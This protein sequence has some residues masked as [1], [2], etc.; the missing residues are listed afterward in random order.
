M[1]NSGSASQPISAS[2][3]NRLHSVSTTI[4]LQSPRLSQGHRLLSYQRGFV[5]TG[6]SPDTPLHDAMQSPGYYVTNRVVTNY[7]CLLT[8]L[9]EELSA[10]LVPSIFQLS[11]WFWIGFN[12]TVLILNHDELLFPTTCMQCL[13]IYF[14]HSYYVLVVVIFCHWGLSIFIRISR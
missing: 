1:L 12:F 8:S 14:K 13:Q 10:L 3:R 2:T 5:R 7:I 9:F 4:I 11:L 6:L